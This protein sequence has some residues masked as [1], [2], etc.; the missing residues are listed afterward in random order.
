MVIECSGINVAFASNVNFT[1]VLGQFA[2]Y[3]Q[4]SWNALYQK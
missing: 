2:S 4:I 1:T 3:V